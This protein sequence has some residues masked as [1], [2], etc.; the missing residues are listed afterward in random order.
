MSNE[1]SAAVWKRDFATPS[2]KAVAVR[3]AD[4][5]DDEGRGIWPSVER[6]AAQCNLSERTVQRTLAA[7]VE[8]GIL[9]VVQAGGAGPAATTRYDFAMDVVAGLPLARWRGMKC[10]PALPAAA[11]ENKGDTVSPFAENKGDTVSEKGDTVSQKGCH[12]VTQTIR[13]PSREPSDAREDAREG[14]PVSADDPK[15]FEKRVKR[16]GEG[17]PGWA[18]SSTGWTISQFARLTDAER[19]DAERCATRY[20]AHCGKQA[21]SLGTYL[22][23]RKWLDL[24]PEAPPVVLP[25]SAAPFGKLWGAVLI[26][27]LLN[28]APQPGPPPPRQIAA[29]IAAD[30]EA[31]R[32]A[33]LERQAKFGWPR[34]NQMLAAA[35]FGR[36]STIAPLEAA[37]LESAAAG[38]VQVR[39]R[40]DVWGAWQVE[41][42]RRG[43][44][45][46]PDPGRLEWVWLPAGGPGGLEAF[47][48][49]V[50][51]K[52]AHGT[53]HK[54]H[55][56]DRHQAAE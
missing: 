30:G 34:V 35:E 11:T 41:F 56:A 42:E 55:D 28:D 2:R 29:D 1:C 27:I 52:P 21:L 45:W 50:R 53:G 46:L 20:L 36:G 5:A 37:Q 4:H 33:R 16:M 15:K 7:F 9:V 6:V 44:P 54:D 49:A 40:T 51:A 48:E 24:P 19:T 26:K 32:K 14:A 47:E 25:V 23:E 39:V 22:A 43:W 3:L 18:N 10:A 31:G 8:E 12:G 38:F 13:E 17:W